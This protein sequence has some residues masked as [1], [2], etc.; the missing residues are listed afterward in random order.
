METKTEGERKGDVHM[1]RG[2]FIIIHVDAETG[3]PLYVK[4]CFNSSCKDCVYWDICKF[5]YRAK[6]RVEIT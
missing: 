6:E 3:L 1:M 2:S 5:R 4:Q